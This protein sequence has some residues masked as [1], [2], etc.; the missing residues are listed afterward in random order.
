V[1]VPTTLTAADGGTA[2][3]AGHDMAA[4]AKAVRAAIGFT[5]RFAAVDELPTRRE[6]LQLMADLKRLRAA[7]SKRV[8]GGLL[9]RF[10]L[11]ESAASWCRPIPAACG[12]SWTWR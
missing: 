9:D 1:N 6:N 10:H 2:R 3:V 7:E 8:I 12:G 5:G 4:Q 11:A